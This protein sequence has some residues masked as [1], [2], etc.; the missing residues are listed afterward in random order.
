[1]GSKY[2][3]Q[4]IVSVSSD[5]SRQQLIELSVLTFSVE[6]LSVGTHIKAALRPRL[7]DNAKCLFIGGFDFGAVTINV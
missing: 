1:M 6:L 7:L 3:Q 5:S 4:I 2:P